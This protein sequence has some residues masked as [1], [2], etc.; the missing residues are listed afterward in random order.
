MSVREI[1]P[2]MNSPAGVDA[3]RDAPPDSVSLMVIRVLSRKRADLMK[4]VQ[5]PGV[6]VW[7]GCRGSPEHQ[8]Q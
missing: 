5:Q 1:V 6:S 7:E 8:R 4:L 2:I 3:N